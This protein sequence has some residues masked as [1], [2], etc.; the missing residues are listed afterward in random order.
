MVEF[1]L[2]HFCA[3][4]GARDKFGTVAGG[5]ERELVYRTNVTYFCTATIIVIILDLRFGFRLPQHSIVSICIWSILACGRNLISH[6]QSQHPPD[7]RRAWGVE[8]S[9]PVK[10]D[11]IGERQKQRSEIRNKSS[12][13]GGPRPH[14]RWQK[15]M[16]FGVRWQSFYCTSKPIYL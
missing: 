4:N 8:T 5:R 11:K 12:P 16:R 3:N 1:Q 10:E 6:P 15:K 9:I 14:G 13:K 2:I 7:G